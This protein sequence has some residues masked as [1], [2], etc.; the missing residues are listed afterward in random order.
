MKRHIQADE[1][2]S[3]YELGWQDGTRPAILLRIEEGTLKREFRPLERLMKKMSEAAK[4]PF[5]FDLEKRTGF[6]EMYVERTG[7]ADGFAEFRFPI[8]DL[9]GKSDTCFACRGSGRNSIMERTCEL[10]RGRK[11]HRSPDWGKG[12]RATRTLGVF[13]ELLQFPERETQAS[14]PQLLTV[15]VY[16]IDGQSM[17]GFPVGGHMGVPLSRWL[18]SYPERMQLEECLAAMKAASTRM[19]GKERHGLYQAWT[20]PDGRFHLSV[21][22]NCACLGSMDFHAAREGR[23]GTFNSHNVDGPW[24]QLSLVAGVAA[25]H[26][27]ARKEIK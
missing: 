3:W 14:K 6:G 7:G 9:R 17:H 20:E 27:L 24:Q 13:L 11:R 23:G 22:G 19:I 18:A 10:C 1:L 26:D 21:P 16:A 25:L 15:Q 4:V 2:P 8:P 5:T 12:R